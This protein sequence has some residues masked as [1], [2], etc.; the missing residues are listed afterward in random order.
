MQLVLLSLYIYLLL[1]SQ[2]W[3]F[4]LFFLIFDVCACAWNAF[5]FHATVSHFSAYI[6]RPLLS[7]KALKFLMWKTPPKMAFVQHGNPFSFSFS[8]SDFVD[9]QTYRQPIPFKQNNEKIERKEEKNDSH[10]QLFPSCTDRAFILSLRYY[11]MPPKI[12]CTKIIT[13]K[14]TATTTTT[15]TAT[16]HMNMKG[17]KYRVH[18]DTF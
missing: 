7:R 11:F 12:Q 14:I 15:T 4:S 3:F 6:F 8:L 16:A 18:I 2:V 5:G 9:F 10:K 1:L 13:T 17:R